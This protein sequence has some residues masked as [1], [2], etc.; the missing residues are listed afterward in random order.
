RLRR[1]TGQPT[2]LARHPAAAGAHE[3]GASSRA[4]P[5][6]PRGACAP[7]ARRPDAAVCYRDILAGHFD[8]IL[9]QYGNARRLAALVLVNESDAGQKTKDERLA[10]LAVRPWSFAPRFLAAPRI[11]LCWHSACL[12]LMYHGKAC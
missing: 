7:L 3:H 5:S 4:L 12:L 9:H 11:A 10:V 1:A 2:D 8:Y 6:R